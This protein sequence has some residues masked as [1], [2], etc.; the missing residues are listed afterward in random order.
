MNIFITG[1]TGSL[2]TALARWHWDRGDRN[3]FGCARNEK[4]IAECRSK[5]PWGQGIFCLDAKR[6]TPDRR[7]DRLYHCAAM[8]HIEHCERFPYEA[9]IQNIQVTKVVIEACRLAQCATIFPSTDKVCLPNSVYG[10]TKLIAEKMVV[11]AGYAVVRFGN[12]IGSSGSVFSK[13]QLA[14][15]RKEPIELTDPEMTRFFLPL[16][17]AAR[18]MAT[19]GVPGYVV[20]PAMKAI[21][22]GDLADLWPSPVKIIGLRPGE[23]LHEWAI[24]PGEKAERLG[25]VFVIANGD[26]SPGYSSEKALQ[27][28][29]WDITKALEE[30]GCWPQKPYV[31][32]G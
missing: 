23:R 14:A 18:I 16:Q 24:T 3:I 28:K 11:D 32:F 9:A 13:W 10:A 19:K 30:V 6:L 7:I 21:C 12:L 4:N 17:E 29:K 8:K 2:G 26:P 1:I 5:Y 31:M 15:E 20:V 25:D 27:W 22:M